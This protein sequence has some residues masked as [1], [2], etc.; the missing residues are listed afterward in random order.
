MVPIFYEEL[1]IYF[2]SISLNESAS[3]LDYSL[4]KG[5]RNKCKIPHPCMG[6][7]PHALGRIDLRELVDLWN[8]SQVLASLM[9]NIEESKY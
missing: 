7:F 2:V 6:D 3:V 8:L 5:R 9:D 4:Q 1:D